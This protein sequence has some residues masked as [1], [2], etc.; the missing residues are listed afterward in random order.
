MIG[1]HFYMAPYLQ[2]G[3]SKQK[4]FDSTFRRYSNAIASRDYATAY[5][6]GSREFQGALSEP[7]FMT[8]EQSLE[9][10]WGKLV[11]STTENF[12]IDG[13]LDPI[14]WTA[15]LRERRRYQNG[16]VHLLYEFHFVDGRWELFGYKV[17]K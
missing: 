15:K 6:I 16:D 3:R 14:E 4:A 12:T 8:G 7:D 9:S 5:S 10:K 13:Q 2:A 1:L 17:V 11:S